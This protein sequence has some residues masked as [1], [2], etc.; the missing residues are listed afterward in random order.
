MMKTTVRVMGVLLVLLSAASVFG[1]DSG[2]T[3]EEVNE[4]KDK[5]E[6][7]EKIIANQN[8]PVAKETGGKHWFQRIDM[9]I[10]AGGVIQGSSGAEDDDLDGTAR[11]EL[12]LTYT[13]SPN[14]VFYLHLEG[15]NGEGLD[16]RV[17]T[18]SSFNG[19]AFGDDDHLSVSE[20]WYL[21]RLQWADAVLQIGKI[22]LGG[23]GDNSPDDAIAFDAN[24][25]A[26][27]ER[28]QFLS[29]GFVNNL[30]LEFPDNGLGGM[31]RISANDFLD[32]SAG[33]AD[34]AG[35]WSNVFDDLFSILEINFKPKMAGHQGN[36]RLYG[37]FNGSDHEDLKDPTKT[38]EDNYGFGLSFDQELTDLI[39]IFARYGWQR[40]SVSQVEHAWSTGF[41]S[42]GKFYGRENDT[43]GLAY[44]MAIIGEDWKDANSGINSGNEHHMELYY[45]FKVSDHLNISPDIQWVKNPNGDSENDDIWVF[46]IRAQLSF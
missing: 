16:N 13:V 17:A 20:A 14:D 29:G 45:N 1:Q 7:L 34:A 19:N 15:G 42:S 25:Y 35:E 28:S 46:G 2:V 36:Y 24:E 30:A 31:V 21:H 32:I 6:R 23:P 39:G 5:I 43:F 40:S 4:L 27:N 38:R 26:N 33:V 11:Y 18:L 8:S 12:E 9:G 22:S 3:R 44:G 41:Q 37:W 10:T